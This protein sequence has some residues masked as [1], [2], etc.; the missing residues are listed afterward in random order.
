M[1]KH[2]VVSHAVACRPKKIAPWMGETAPRAMGRVR[3]RETVRSSSW[4]MTS[5][6]VHPAERWM[7]DVKKRV[8][9]EERVARSGAGGEAGERMVA[10]RRPRR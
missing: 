7:T 4:S 6:Q 8:E 1:R 9:A 2:K 10:R 5:F 3:Q